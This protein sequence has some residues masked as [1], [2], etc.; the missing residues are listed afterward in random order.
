MSNIR[1]DSIY[2]VW[3]FK[4]VKPVKDSSGVLKEGSIKNYDLWDLTKKGTLSYTVTDSPGTIHSVPYQMINNAI[5]LQL[6]NNENNLAVRFKITE[7]T[8]DKLKLIVHVTYTIKGKTRDEDIIELI[9][10]A[11]DK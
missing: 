5:V 11:K 8:S 10:E 6:P 2:K 7:L 4:T 9:F 3:K 1:Q